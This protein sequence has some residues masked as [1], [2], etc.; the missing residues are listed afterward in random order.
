MVPALLKKS[1]L[2]KCEINMM[3]TKATIQQ[4]LLLCEEG[5]GEVIAG[6]IS[7]I[8]VATSRRLGPV[9]TEVM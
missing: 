5:M 9:T 6:A 1:Q 8:S 3:L 7:I 4:H 2:L